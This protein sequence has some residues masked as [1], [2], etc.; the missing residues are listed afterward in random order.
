MASVALDTVTARPDVAF[1]ANGSSSWLGL[2]GKLILFLLHIIS[3]ILYW[4]LK[5]TTISAPTLLFNLFSTSLTVTMNATTLMLIMALMF[6]GV[7]WVVRYRY[8]NMYSRLPPEPQRKEPEL[9]L[10]PDSHEEGSKA[11]LTNYLDE[12]LS[13]IKI[14][15]YLERPV[16][17]ELTRSMQTRKLIAGETLNLEDE[18][19]FCLVVD[20]LVEIFVKSSQA[21]RQTMSMESS[22][23]EDDESS[24]S[25]QQRYQ[26]LTEVRNGAPMSS[27]FS[28]MSLFTEDVKLCLPA[29][30]GASPGPANGALNHDQYPTSAGSPPSRHIS[31]SFAKVPRFEEPN[32]KPTTLVEEPEDMSPVSPHGNSFHQIPPISLDESSMPRLPRRPAPKR[33]STNSAHPDVIA[34]AT[35][36]TTI[37][38]IPASAFRRLIKIYP[39]ATAHI[40]HVIISRFQRV[41]LA[42]AY[43]YLGLTNDVLQTEKNM[44]KF[45]SCP[46][47]NL[48][49]G[50]ALERLKEKFRKERQ[51]AGDED[52]GKGIALHNA[53]ATARRRRS[54]AGLRKEAAMQAM[55]KKKP[56]SVVASTLAPPRERS[57]IHTSGPGDLLANIQSAR[58]D[59]P[60]GLI[61]I[62][63]TQPWQ[64]GD[65]LSNPDASP[66][67]QRTFDPFPTQKRARISVDPR[68]SVD[69]DNLFRVSILECVFT[70][71]GMSSGGSSHGPEST[72]GSPRLVSYDQRRQKAVFSSNAF[73]FMESVDGSADW[74]AES[75][76]SGGISMAGTPNAHVLA[77][78]MKHE[79][80]IV[81][82][83]KG[84]VLVEQGERSPGIYYVIDGFLDICVP[85]DDNTSD[86]L[87]SSGKSYHSAMEKAESQVSSRRSTMPVPHMDSTNTIPG[88]F[89]STKKSK[90]G[91]RRV[92]LVK[93]GGLAG[94]IGTISS[95][96][97]FLDVV[98]KTDVYVGFIP[99]A[100][101]ERIVERYPIIMLTMAKRL[102][103]LLPRLILHIDF[104]LEWVQV[105]AGQV[106]FH[107]EDE[108]EAI[109]L[110]LNGRLRL[111]EDKREGG[112]N[113]RAEFGQ[114]DSVGELE[115]LT[116]SARSGTLHA[117]RD[118]ELVKFPRTLFNSLAQEHPNI[119]IKISKIIASR[120]RFMIDDPSKGIGKEASTG[121]S[122]NKISSTLNLRTVA[123][124]PVTS[125]VPVVEFGTRLMNALTQI[126]T[127]NGATSLNQSAILNHLGKHAFNKMGKLKLSHYL[128]DLEEKYGLVV[129]VADTNVN[130]PWT[131]TCITQADC[132]LLVGLAEG[133]PEIG[134]YER[135]ML[136]QKSTARK[137]LVLLHADRYSH[138]GLTRAWLKNR[139]WI[140]GGHLHMQMAFRTN[141]VPVH[142][143]SS[144]LGATLKER[145]QILQAEIQKYTTKRLRHRPYYSP[146]APHK[147]DFHR[148]ARRL[149]GRSIGLVLGGGGARGITQV[150]IITA[151][152]EAGIPIDIVGGTSIGSFI[153]ALYARHADVVPMFGLA[154]KFSGRMA[155][156]WRFALD[157]TY[158]SASYTTGHEFNR[159]IFKTFGNHQ[160]EDF[161]LEYYC[162]TTNISKSRH[163][164]HTS[165]Y[166]WRYIRASMTLAGL[167]PPLCDE[168]SMLVDGGYVDNLT[169]SHMKS[170]GADVIFAIDVGALDDTTPQTYGDSLSGMWAFFNRWNPLSSHPN[171]PTLAEIQGR[172]AYVSSVDAL[173]RAKAMP[174]CI[175]MRPPIDDYGTLDFGKFDELYQLGH[176]YGKD[177]I[178][179]LREEGALP[180]ATE[181][182]A[183]KALRR[184]MA[185]RRASI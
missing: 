52:M 47:P 31:G 138:P 174:G 118:T 53:S 20:G 164:I 85:S 117:I 39:K 141:A 147:G 26:L 156:M 56:T 23:T 81:Y 119:T 10:P 159:G 114:G 179:R 48:L 2:V 91:H 80:E 5:L 137:I 107:K 30:S 136:G 108:S 89:D 63:L 155:S 176:Q 125:G 180:V 145:V 124:L 120:M 40:V 88:A 105:N 77:A 94:Y 129:Y 60:R 12:F 42:T 6:S 7:T 139:S 151:M 62:A 102:T 79:V 173:E 17:H 172:L 153:G 112:M 182:E 115:V 167:L 116:E 78:D 69:E 43:N 75:M 71:L 150:G 104:A 96:R 21:A 37:A 55:T 3:T 122:I 135:F 148:L 99:R 95:Y 157:L 49:R 106:L 169:V 163:E 58:A 84:S 32:G 97:S 8:L 177:F 67:A 45:T 1:A 149:C 14:F 28:I 46:L 83:P 70:A 57:S 33:V 24:S 162:N 140:N 61:E 171:P 142:A 152:E 82:F 13:A 36:D 68:E 74:D 111:I 18:K 41:T 103:N 51:R 158:P 86:I 134:E 92:G 154:K 19:G 178:A 144:K 143:P 130:S 93:P 181:T 44:L 113:V 160:I 166:A 161:W 146:D 101:L 175:Y 34:R 133:S 87:S 126:G 59:G 131:Q 165:G 184:T 121:T 65:S 170:I 76:T 4:S 66:L 73:G 22:S 72:E 35:V 27:L 64:S 110:V 127:P 185:P 15:G 98:A 16:F 183:K 128:A 132:I 109:Y 25:G 100:T 38:V 9:D 123:I 50:D 54:S 90:L 29:D 168:G 11:G